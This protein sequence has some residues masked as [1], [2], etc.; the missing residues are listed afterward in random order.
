M[1]HR[2]ETFTIPDSQKKHMKTVE[3][4]TKDPICGM[5]VDAATAI[6]AEREGKTYYF[7]GETCRKKFLN[8]SSQK[9]AGTPVKSVTLR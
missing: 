4:Q 3:T 2:N 6:H 1:N 9:K 8:P 5:A 7:C